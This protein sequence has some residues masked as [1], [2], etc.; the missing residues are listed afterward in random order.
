MKPK[1]VARQAIDQAA[2]R[3][4]AEEAADAAKAAAE[5]AAKAQ[6]EGGAAEGE[7]GDEAAVLPPPPGDPDAFKVLSWEAFVT[8]KPDVTCWI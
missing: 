3:A 8:P 6:T 4:A 5:K 7:A 2:A 1:A